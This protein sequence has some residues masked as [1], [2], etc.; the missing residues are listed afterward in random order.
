MNQISGLDIRQLVEVELIEDEN[1]VVYRSRV[2]N[3]TNSCIVLGAPMEG[4]RPVPM[5]P[6]TKIRVNYYDDNA[7]YT[8]DS[9]VIERNMGTLL[10][11]SIDRPTSI[12]RT[13][14]RNFVRINTKLPVSYNIINDEM[15]EAAIFQQ[16]ITLDISGG[17]IRFQTSVFLPEG[18]VV[19][20]KVDIQGHGQISALGKVIRTISSGEKEKKSYLIGVQFMIIEEKDRDKIIRHIFDKQRELRQ[21]GLL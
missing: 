20:L 11:I 4:G 6:G 15:S 21:R 14:R 1:P 12:K 17:G 7:T 16:G 13:Q 3:I 5:P 2:E 10:Q 19:E 18:T 9:S 8:F